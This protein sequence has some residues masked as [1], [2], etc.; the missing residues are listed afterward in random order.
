MRHRQAFVRLS[1][2]ACAAP[3]LWL[4][5]TAFRLSRAHNLSS[6]GPYHAPQ[7][8]AASAAVEQKRK[9]GA[10]GELCDSEEV[11]LNCARQLGA[12]CDDYISMERSYDDLDIC[13]KCEPARG[14]RGW[15][16]GSWGWL[17]G[18]FGWPGVVA[19][20]CQAGLHCI[21]T[22]LA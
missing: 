4:P 17:A 18:A 10:T 8:T 22:K 9:Q 15:R 3:P 13:V 1:P 7:K 14:R 16:D 19:A 5:Q 2:H 6:H 21:A 20:L 11:T 12:N